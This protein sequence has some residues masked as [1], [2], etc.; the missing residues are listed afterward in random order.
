MTD[1]V[2][3]DSEPWEEDDF[4]EAK[5]YPAAELLFSAIERCRL[6]L[7]EV[8]EGRERIAQ[9]LERNDVTPQELSFPEFIK[10]AFDL[11]EK[12]HESRIWESK[13]AKLRRKWLSDQ[14]SRWIDARR[15]IF[16]QYLYDIDKLLVQELRP[17]SD[18]RCRIRAEVRHLPE[19]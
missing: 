7:A 16:R 1:L 11:D 2:F 14:V 13:V 4:D 5:L 3:S 6:A 19:A 17:E 18:P 15:M 10:L 9:I 12:S 8:L